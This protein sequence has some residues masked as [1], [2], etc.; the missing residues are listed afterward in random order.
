MCQNNSKTE[1]KR[2]LYTSIFNS[3][4]KPFCF[5]LIVNEKHLYLRYLKAKAMFWGLLINCVCSNKLKYQSSAVNRSQSY[6]IFNTLT[7][8][9]YNTYYWL[10][11]DF[12]DCYMFCCA[13]VLLGQISQYY[14]EYYYR[15]IYSYSNIQET[16]SNREILLIFQKAASKQN[17]MYI[18]VLISSVV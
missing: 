11:F 9:I 1:C 18:H 2:V 10:T 13:Q 17:V 14:R 12:E 3:T 6:D 8:N 15:V 7:L 4:Q 5:H 16:L